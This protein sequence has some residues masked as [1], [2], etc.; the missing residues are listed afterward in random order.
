MCFRCGG[1]AKR[2][3]DTLDTLFDSTWYFLRYLDPQNNQAPF[4]PNIANDWMP[5]HLYIGGIEHGDE[6]AFNSL[7]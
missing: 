5:V 1:E 4:A 2:D 3:A 6:T 7:L